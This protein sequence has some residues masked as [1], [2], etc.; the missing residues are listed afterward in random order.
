VVGSGSLFGCWS[1]V[2]LAQLSLINYFGAGLLLCGSHENRG[3]ATKG[4]RPLLVWEPLV[5]D[6][7]YALGPFADEGKLTRR[8]EWAKSGSGRLFLWETFVIS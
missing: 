2:L 6:T 4:A 1:L 5:A 8:W 7:E 3:H